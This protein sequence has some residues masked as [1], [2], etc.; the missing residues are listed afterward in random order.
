MTILGPALP[1]NGW[2]SGPQGEEKSHG[3]HFTRKQWT[4]KAKGR[5]AFVDYP[6]NNARGETA[7]VG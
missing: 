5:P 4:V 3:K 6:S 7:R 1:L 2:P